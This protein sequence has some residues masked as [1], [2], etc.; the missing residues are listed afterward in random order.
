[1]LGFVRR[2]I[3]RRSHNIKTKT[4]KTLVCP[5]LEY[6]TSVWDPHTQSATQKVEMVKRRASRYVLRR[7]HNTSSVSDMLK[8]LQW[9]T[10]A[11]RY[12][13]SALLGYLKSIPV[14]VL[15]Q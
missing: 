14:I 9:P 5:H 2:S 6:C 11:Q 4:Y 10:L 12:V 1:M 7:Y 3:E 15:L 8:Q 13:A